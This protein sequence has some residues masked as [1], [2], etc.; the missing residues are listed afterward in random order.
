MSDE[1]VCAV[2]MSSIDPGDDAS[3]ILNCSQ[4]TEIH[5]DCLKKWTVAQRYTK[6]KRRECPLCRTPYD[7]HNESVVVPMDEADDDSDSFDTSYT[8]EWRH[9]YGCIAVLTFVGSLSRFMCA[10]NVPLIMH[11]TAHQVGIVTFT[12]S[13][14]KPSILFWCACLLMSMSALTIS[15]FMWFFRPMEMRIDPSLLYFYF[16]TDAIILTLNF[17]VGVHRHLRAPRSPWV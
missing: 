5:R 4:G 6:H 13:M 1:N 16:F 3:S 2:C 10:E 7:V 15:T 11:A 17:I 14:L 12:I 9:K 8:G